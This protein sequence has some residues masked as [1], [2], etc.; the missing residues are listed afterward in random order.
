MKNILLISEGPIKRTGQLW[1]AV[2]KCRSIDTLFYMSGAEL[3][4]LVC[5]TNFCSYH[6]VVF[7]AGI[8]RLGRSA[9]TLTKIPNLII[10]DFDLGQDF[11]PRSRYRGKLV[12]LLKYLPRSRLIVTSEASF[13]H[14]SSHGLNCSYLPKGYDSRVIYNKNSDRIYRYGFVGR[15]KNRVYQKRATFLKD[16]S[17]ILDLSILRTADSSLESDEYNNILNK[18]NIF[19]S[20][21]FDFLEYMQKVFEAMAAGCIVC[22]PRTSEAESSFLGFEDMVNIVFFGSLD[23]LIMKIR[24]LDSCSATV[25][26][27]RLES[28]RLAE[29]RHS[30]LSRADDFLEILD[31][32]VSEPEP[33]SWR[34][35]VTL[36]YLKIK[37]I[38]RL[39]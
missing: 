7:H 39:L 22:V 38:L 14:Y 1:E 9:F 21:D 12:P 11:H 35:R 13:L 25:D 23:E 10:Y 32:P 8:R 37:F 30:W 17:G 34:E 27:I 33:S 36:K 29:E 19:I 24:M 2:S 18:I 5:K 4:E 6:R 16:L 20:P 3:E 26:R 31:L 28:L 15:I